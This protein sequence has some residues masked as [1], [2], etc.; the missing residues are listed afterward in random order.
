MKQPFLKA[1]PLLEIIEANGFEAYFVGGSVRDYL[2]D[3]EITDIDIA[4]SA[5]PAE[6]KSIFSKTIDVGIEHGTVVVIFEGE[7]Y[8]VTTFR[9]EEEYM[10]YR[11]PK[12]VV[13][14]RS[15][16][17]DLE[18]RDFTMNAMAMDKTGNIIDPF[19]GR[20]AIED[21]VIKTVGMAEERFKEDALRMM[22]ALRFSSQ[23]C[24]EIDS[25]TFSG[26]VQYGYLLEKIAV[27]RL[28]VEFE[29]LLSGQNRNGALK[30]LLK[31]GL[32]QFLPGFHS[33]QQEIEKLSEMTIN[34]LHVDEIWLLLTHLLGLNGK[35][36]EPFLR[37]WKFPVKRIHWI[38]KCLNW[39]ENR[40]KKEWT[41]ESIYHANEEVFNSV[42]RVFNIV[43]GKEVNASINHLNQVYKSLPIKCHSDLVVSGRDLMNWYQADAGPWIKEKLSLIEEAVLHKIIENKKESIRE[44]L[45]SCNQ[46]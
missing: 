23:L 33:H 29:K 13:F 36:V 21:K 9:A 1:V 19:F 41:I 22:R 42:E 7:T 27:E 3:R 24:F 35:N 38:Q 16:I 2:L 28:L 6:I 4:S 26:L 14:I 25:A 32:F 17:A 15:L 37:K 12:E 40:L 39:L 10:D 30:L 46:S 45:L 18:R 43:S 11:R 5:T 20:Q 34:E 8:E 31:S 44:W